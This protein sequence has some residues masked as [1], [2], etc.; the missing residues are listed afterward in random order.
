[1]SLPTAI[2]YIKPVRP[3]DLLIANRA[4]SIDARSSEIL[5]REKVYIESW[6]RAANVGRSLRQVE[7][8]LSGLALSGGGVRSA[9]FALGVT[10]AF[11]AQDLIR[12][13]RDFVAKRK[14][15]TTEESTL[16]RLQGA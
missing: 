4:A 14:K 5:E 9:T 10:Q 11:A 2:D 13:S 16:R 8:T 15:L 3:E 1:M 12:L 7:Q 6:R